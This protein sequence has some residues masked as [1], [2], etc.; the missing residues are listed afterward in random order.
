MTNS[1]VGSYCNPVCLSID[2]L[3]VECG[4]EVNKLAVDADVSHVKHK[5]LV[6]LHGIVA[7]WYEEDWRVKWDVQHDD[8]ALLLR[9]LLLVLLDVQHKLTALVYVL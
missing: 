7:L 5:E 3:V 8:R 6:P 2:K 9:L 4:I 1:S